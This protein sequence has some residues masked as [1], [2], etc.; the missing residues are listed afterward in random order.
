MQSFLSSHSTD[1]Q[2][3]IQ[4]KRFQDIV[5]LIETV[6]DANQST[7]TYK[8]ALQ[9][10]LNN[11]DTQI[12]S[13]AAQRPVLKSH[14]VDRVYDERGGGGYTL[15]IVQAMDNAKEMFKG[16]E[17][18]IAGIKKKVEQVRQFVESKDCRLLK[19]KSLALDTPEKLFALLAAS[20]GDVETTI[21][22]CKQ[23]DAEGAQFNDLAG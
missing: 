15:K 8:K 11:P 7:T 1:N 9:S 20:D 16:P 13:S 2:C 21:M 6:S 19:N 22:A 18:L 12:F 10:F 5:E 4:G 3:L 14:H 23:L 17:A